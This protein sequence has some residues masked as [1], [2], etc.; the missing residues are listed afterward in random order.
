[1]STL[2]GMRSVLVTLAA[3]ALL[4]SCGTRGQLGGRVGV[5]R[6]WLL[7]QHGLERP[8]ARSGPDLRG[9]ARAPAPGRPMPAPR[10]TRRR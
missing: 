2:I 3:A 4:G 1:M 10:P 6:H 7:Q 9:A 8:L 5:C